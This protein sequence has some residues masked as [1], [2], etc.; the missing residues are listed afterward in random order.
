MQEYYNLP[1]LYTREE[2]EQY[3]KWGVK[4]ARTLM[5]TGLLVAGIDLT[6]TAGT[7]I[8]AFGRAFG[9]GS[10]ETSTFLV[11]CSSRISWLAVVIF[12]LVVIKPMDLLFD[13]IFKKPQE[14]MML[15]LEPSVE[16]VIY[17]LTRGKKQLRSGVLSWPQWKLVVYPQLN[18]IMIE[19]LRL[20]IGENTVKS[21]YPPHLQHKWMEHPA[22]KI[23]GTIN[24]GTI[25]K[26][27]EGYLAALEEQKREAEWLKQNG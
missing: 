27:M 17:T 16:G 5:P 18:E 26:N 15:R 23:V 14:P 7:V 21:I 11:M 12:T 9:G 22:E 4:K 6:V 10:Y 20:K 3:M 19:E 24:L 25:Q 13:F 8:Y 2:R 1:V